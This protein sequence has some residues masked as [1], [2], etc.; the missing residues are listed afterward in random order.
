MAEASFEVYDNLTSYRRLQDMINDGETEGLHIECKSPSVPKLNRE[1]KV[2]LAKALSGFS[3]TAGG[4]VIWG[5]ST[6]KHDH[7]GLDVLSQIEP[8]GNIRQFEQQITRTIPTLATPSVVNFQTK[9][10][11]RRS[12]DTRGVVVV[13]IPKSHSD[14][15]QSNQDNLFYFRSGDEFSIAPYEM[16]KRLFSATD[17]P[18]LSPLFITDLVK[19]QDDGSF[20]IPIVIQNKSSAIG[21]DIH[22]SVTIENANDCEHISASD[23]SDRSSV[24]PGK[25]IYMQNISSVVHRGLDLLVGH[26]KITMKS[27]KRRK[28]R[29]D[30]SIRLFANRMVAKEFRYAVS[31]TKTNFSVRCLKEGALY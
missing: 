4:I 3:N 29:L 20:E 5:V 6:T 10:L 19:P 11:K 27:G 9:I 8:L 30:V 22:V 15:C 26:I 31:L 1:H 28:R 2:H 21:E 16:V 14:P 17:S 18:D 23:L 25:R 13:H 7:S 24:N 12:S